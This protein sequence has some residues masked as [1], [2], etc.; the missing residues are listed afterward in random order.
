[1][2]LILLY[3]YHY[4]FF[5]PT[6]IP[7]HTCEHTHVLNFFL[8]KRIYERQQ[9]SEEEKLQL[10]KGKVHP[11]HGLCH[12]LAEKG[13]EEISL[14]YNLSYLRSHQYYW[15]EQSAFPFIGKRD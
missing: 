3:G 4:Y 11:S 7:L 14:W 5:F 12:A 8:L 6:H 1:M 15:T 10:V 9:V 13:N 2:K